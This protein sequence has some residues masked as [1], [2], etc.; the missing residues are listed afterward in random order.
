LAKEP[1]RILKIHCFAKAAKDLISRE[2]KYDNSWGVDHG[3][4]SVLVHM[5]PNRDI[6]AFPISIDADAPPEEHYKI[7]RELKTLREQGVLIFGTGNIVHN[8]R[9]VD[10]HKANKGFDWAY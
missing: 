1:L 2:T 6:P 4:W 10:W 8:L 5:Y 7:G 9:L 3:T